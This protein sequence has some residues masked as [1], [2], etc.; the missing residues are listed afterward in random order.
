MYQNDFMILICIWKT[1]SKEL[2]PICLWNS[3]GDNEK[4][5]LCIYT[6]T[7]VYICNCRW[8]QVIYDLWMYK[9]CITK[10]KIKVGRY[11]ECMK[12]DVSLMLK[13]WLSYVKW[14]WTCMNQLL[15]T[16]KLCHEF[17]PWLLWNY[18]TNLVW[19]YYLGWIVQSCE[20]QRKNILKNKTQ[21]YA[22][23][24]SIHLR[25]MIFVS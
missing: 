7:Q 19:N 4:S 14:K 12:D 5:S 11:D 21:E 9:G 23:W 6:H 8:T 20:C 13:N 24:L 17:N 10:E 25:K 1:N 18:M 16:L 2:S 3:P 15:F 22:F